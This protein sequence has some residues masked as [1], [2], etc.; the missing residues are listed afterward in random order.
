[1][2][3]TRGAKQSQLEDRK[4]EESK[5]EKDIDNVTNQEGRWPGAPR[6]HIC[7]PDDRLNKHADSEID[8]IQEQAENKRNVEGRADIL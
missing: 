3:D 5:A 4:Y 6:L 2:D 7:Q 1:M 8:H